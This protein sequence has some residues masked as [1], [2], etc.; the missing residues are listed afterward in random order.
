MKMCLRITVSKATLSLPINKMAIQWLYLLYNYQQTNFRRYN[1][2]S[3]VLTQTNVR[4]MLIRYRKFKDDC[5]KSAN[6]RNQNISDA[7]LVHIP[8]HTYNF[9]IWRMLIAHKA[10]YKTTCSLTPL[11]TFKTQICWFKCFQ[12]QHPAL[13]NIGA[14]CLSSLGDLDRPQ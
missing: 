14:F 1:L 3:R 5:G 4:W 6:K 11:R 8:S 10:T 12:F 2:K 13:N 7:L 9:E